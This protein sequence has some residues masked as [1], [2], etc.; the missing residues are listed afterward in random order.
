MGTAMPDL[1]GFIAFA[2]KVGVA[3]PE[4]AAPWSDADWQAAFDERAGILEYDAGLPRDEAE[5]LARDEIERLKAE[6]YQ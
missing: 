4:P 3:I 1:S 2:R 5:Q 6:S